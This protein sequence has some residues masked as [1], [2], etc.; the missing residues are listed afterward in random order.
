MSAVNLAGPAIEPV[1]TA[2]LRDWLR[3][4]AADEDDALA[5]LLTTARVTLESHTRRAFVSQT[6]RFTY[7]SSFTGGAL[8]LPMAPLLSLVALRLYDAAGV[9][10]SLSLAN[11]EMEQDDQRPEVR[12]VGAV[13]PARRVE[14]DA[15]VGYGADPQATPA[16]LRHA[17][18]MLATCWHARRGDHGELD[19]TIPKSVARLVAPYRRVG[20]R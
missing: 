20:L 14:V 8:R 15:V 9:E 11:V 17:I 2:E 13:G 10:T 6:W 16:P 1:T 12:V 19:L 7:G 5:A 18:L 4:D 3:L